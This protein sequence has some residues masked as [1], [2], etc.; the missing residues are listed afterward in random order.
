VRF[1]PDSVLISVKFFRREDEPSRPGLS[2][3]EVDKIQKQIKSGE[4]QIFNKN[5]DK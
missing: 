1:K 5:L 3:N 2:I 4:Y